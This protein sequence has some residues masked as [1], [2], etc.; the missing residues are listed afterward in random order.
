MIK[1]TNLLNE[2][3]T[4]VSKKSG[5]T[6]AFKNKDSRDAAVKAGTHSEDE[7]ADG[8]EEP[9]SDEPNM[10]SKDS[11]YDAPDIKSDE[12]KAEPTKLKYSKDGKM[13]QDSADSIEKE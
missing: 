1:L 3:F 6:V 10:F 2:E 12:P 7:K 8:S 13:T 9:K 11:G 5:K 4:A